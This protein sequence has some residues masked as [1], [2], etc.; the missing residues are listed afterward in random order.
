MNKTLLFALAA[1]ATLFPAR[2]AL[3]A[4]ALPGVPQVPVSLEDRRKALNDVFHDYWEDHLKRHPE[5]ASSSA[6]SATTTRSATTR[7]K[8]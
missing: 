3:R 5:L 7:V 4:Q 2:A 1:F 8:A 6:T